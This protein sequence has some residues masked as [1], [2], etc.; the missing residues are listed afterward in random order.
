VARALTL[1]TLY[2]AMPGVERI[3][4]GSIVCGQMTLVLSRE[5]EALLAIDGQI[6][7]R[8][9]GFF[10]TAMKRIG[11]KSIES[12]SATSDE[13]GPA[14]KRARRDGDQS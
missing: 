6:G 14:I 13:S 10:D 1:T 3:R 12:Q 5:R 9:L 2:E 8:L 11:W 4:M 7:A